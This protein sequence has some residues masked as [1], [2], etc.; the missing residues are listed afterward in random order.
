MYMIILLLETIYSSNRSQDDCHN[1]DKTKNN[2]ATH[3]FAGFLLTLL[4]SL[5]MCD[6]T[7]DMFS[8]F[9]NLYE[10]EK[11]NKMDN[12]YKRVGL[13][14]NTIHSGLSM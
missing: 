7:L 14:M 8:T 12:I 1:Y 9:C 2:S 6:P 5:Q 4:C 11:Y 10:I 13:K 3:P